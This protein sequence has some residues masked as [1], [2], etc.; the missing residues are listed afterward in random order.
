MS[1]DSL[2]TALLDAQKQAMRAKDSA[3][4][5]TLRFLL[6]AVKQ[7][8]VDERRDVS[9]AE[10]TAII[11]KQVK[12]R[13]ESIAAFEAAG[14][15]ETA[16]QEKAELLV[17]QEFLPQAASAEEVEAAIAAAL[18]EVQAQGVT[19]PAVMGKVMAILKAALAGRADMSQLSQQVKARLS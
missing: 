11:E 15:T 1:T 9:D 7:K 5:A 2:K 6:A 12:Q 18:A 13:R 10:I 4:L 19:G 16:E 8:E 17:L 14:R 3:R